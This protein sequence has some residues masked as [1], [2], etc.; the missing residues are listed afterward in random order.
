M[1]QPEGVTT[2]PKHPQVCRKW[3]LA[4]CSQIPAP[5]SRLPCLAGCS[6]GSISYTV[7]VWELFSFSSQ[8]HDC[9]ISSHAFNIAPEQ[10][11]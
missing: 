10:N 5:L 2:I 9:Y 1:A 3:S 8:G 11:C 4:I 7:V 6:S